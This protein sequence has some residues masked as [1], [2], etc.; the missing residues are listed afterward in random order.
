MVF[1]GGDFGRWLGPSLIKGIGAPHLFHH[2]STQQKHSHLWSR[3]WVLTRHQICWHLDLENC[4]A[5]RTVRNKFPL[6]VSYPVMLFCYSSLNRLQHQFC[7]SLKTVKDMNR[8]NSKTS[9]PK[10]FLTQPYKRQAVYSIKK[11]S[12]AV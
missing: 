12:A 7:F 2:G 8:K 10:P 4:P 5:S 1:K 6:F 9:L 3:K 11:T